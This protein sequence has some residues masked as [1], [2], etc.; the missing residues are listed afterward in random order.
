MT[1]AWTSMGNPENGSTN[2]TE[3]IIRNETL[4]RLEGIFRAYAEAGIGGHIRPTGTLGRKVMRAVRR[5][6]GLE[7]A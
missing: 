3:Q 7:G 6:Y 5:E 4:R 1:S 2:H